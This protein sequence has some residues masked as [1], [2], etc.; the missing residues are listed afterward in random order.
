MEKISDLINQSPVHITTNTIVLAVIAIVGFY[1]L[2][3]AIAGLIRIAALIGAC[4]F[5]LMSLQSTNLVNIPVIKE[6]YTTIEK[7]IPAKELWTEAVDKV[8]KI[9]KVVDDL[10]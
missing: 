7:I 5:I 8:G 3:K 4:W 9:N 6:A 1:I 10:K 2:M